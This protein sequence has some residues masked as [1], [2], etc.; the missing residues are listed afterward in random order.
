MDRCRAVALAVLVACVPTAPGAAGTTTERLAY[1]APGE[2]IDLSGVLTLPEAQEQQRLPAVIVVHGSGGVGRREA[3][4][5]AFL[6]QRNYATLVIDY[7][8]PRG[9]TAES[10]SQPTPVG[11][12]FQ[13]LVRLAR[14]PRIDPN[15]IGVLGFSRGGTMSVE[16]ANDGGRSTGGLRAAVH[17]ALYPGC[18]RSVVD[19][20]PS[21]PPLLILLG[22]EDSYTTPWECQRL[23]SGGAWKGRTVE[24]TIYEGATHAFDARIDRTF[25]HRAANRTVT[26]RSSEEHTARARSEVIAFLARS[27]RQR[28]SPVEPAG[29]ATGD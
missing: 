25:Y 15:R 3:E 17:V 7:F 5:A 4:W 29:K 24:L 19:S 26:I 22:S 28:S 23:V 20:D 27:L 12:V 11:D 9:I 1:V 6:Q 18:R 21:L 14:H 10:A 13:A 16:A 2:N 8:G